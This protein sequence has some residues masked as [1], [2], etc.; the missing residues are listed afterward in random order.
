MNIVLAENMT[1]ILCVHVVDHVHLNDKLIIF[2]ILRVRSKDKVRKYM[3]ER[4][5]EWEEGLRLLE[6]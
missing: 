6:D 1:Q 5:M 4:G 2:T 3:R